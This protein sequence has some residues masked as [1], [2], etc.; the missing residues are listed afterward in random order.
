MCWRK[1]KL[2]LLLTEPLC[3]AWMKPS[4]EFRDSFLF[5]S[6]YI[7]FKGRNFL[8]F[9]IFT[10]SVK[11]IATH[12]GLETEIRWGNMTLTKK[13]KKNNNDNKNESYKLSRVLEIPCLHLRHS[14]EKWSSLSSDR[15]YSSLRDCLC[16]IVWRDIS[17]HFSNRPLN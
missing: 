8:F 17:S 5:K 3:L 1:K 2:S 15:S 7:S 12:I 6:L 4:K 13:K 11:F 10:R 14:I 16:P 9:I